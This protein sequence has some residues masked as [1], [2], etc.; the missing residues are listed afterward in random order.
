VWASLNTYYAVLIE[1]KFTPEMV[2]IVSED[3]NEDNLI[4]LDKGIRIISKGFE[5]NPQIRSITVKEGS[6]IDPGI[7]VSGII[8]S[9]GPE[10]NV[11]IDITSGRKAVVAG[12]LLATADR[13]QDHVYY[14]M[15][16]TLE[17]AAKPYPM[18]PY[19][20]QHLIDLKEQTRRIKLG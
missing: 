11:A 14:L 17:D 10:V 12:S 7:E 3:H 2:L 9:M 18:I 4:Q 15:I 19:Q 8:D 13:P 20:H 1:E 5:L 16:D 6:I